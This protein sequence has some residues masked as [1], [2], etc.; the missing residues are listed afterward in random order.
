M[1]PV[2]LGERGFFYP[3]GF[4]TAT[5]CKRQKTWYTIFSIKRGKQ[6]REIEI[7]FYFV[8]NLFFRL[9]RPQ[10]RS[11]PFVCTKCNRK[12][13]ELRL[14]T[15]TSIGSCHLWRPNCRSPRRAPAHLGVRWPPIV[16]HFTVASTRC[17]ARLG[18]TVGDC[19]MSNGCPCEHWK[20]EVKFRDEF[21][22]SFAGN[23]QCLR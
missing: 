6:S 18:A 15:G 19:L 9:L 17:L 4:A 7:V 20:G 16:R 1:C 8:I 3:Q 2:R 10:S 13:T 14:Y 12:S 5:P 21:E 11:L 22:C 23:F